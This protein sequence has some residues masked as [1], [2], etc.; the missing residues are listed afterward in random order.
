MNDQEFAEF[1]DTVDFLNC[2]LETGHKVGTVFF[3]CPQSIKDEAKQWGWSDTV[4]REELCEF[5]E[6]L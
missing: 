5:M 2:E 3:H 6:S 1:K 4:V